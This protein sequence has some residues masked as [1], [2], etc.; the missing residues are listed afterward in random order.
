LP[1]LWE[2]HI[3][4]VVKNATDIV[5]CLSLSDDLKESIIFAARF[6]DHGKRRK[7]FQTVLGNFKYPALILAKS[8][9]KGGRI[10]EPYRHEFG[11]LLDVQLDQAFK[12]LNLEQ[13]EIVLH[14]IAV[15][16]GYGRPHFPVELAFDPEPPPG[17]DSAAVTIAVPQR[18]ARLQRKFGRWGLAYLESLLRA[19]D[20][21]ASGKPSKFVEDEK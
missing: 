21:A 15:H 9:K 11:S 13:Q 12:N 17:S 16:H 3:G 1:V 19:A 4:D 5:N 20:Y 14:L 8:G 6:H 7:K 2:V 10:D 18:F